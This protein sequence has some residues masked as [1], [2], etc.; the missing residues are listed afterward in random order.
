M[1]I[2]IIGGGEIGYALAKALASDHELCVVDTEPAVTDRFGLLD[3]ELL[4]GSG[5]SSSVLER[6]RVSTCDLLIA[7]TGLDEV[8]IVACSIGSQ[9]GCR[10]TIC[11]VSKEDFV[12]TPEGRESLNEHFG[13]DQVVWPE[14]QLADAIERIIMAPG[15]VDA[16]V[17]AGGQIRLLEFRLRSDSPL[18]GRPVSALDLPHGVVIVA[19]HHGE[20]TSIPHGRTVLDIGDKG[21]ADGHPRGDEGAPGAA[22]ARSCEDP[23]HGWSRSSAAATS[24]SGWRST[25]TPSPESSSIWW[26][27]TTR[28]ARCWPPRLVTRSFSK[29]TA[30]T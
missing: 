21:R 23:V 9:L 14:A 17:F 7:C 10:R 11:F 2:I 5:T 19:V 27:T 12:H 8:N 15:S 30:P 1:Q 6:A 22:V 25:S 20:T 29:A 26:S 3:V 4:T 24:G 16:G 13:I 28:V 18:V